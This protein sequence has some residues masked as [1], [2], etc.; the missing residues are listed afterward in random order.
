VTMPERP[1]AAGPRADLEGAATPAEPSRANCVLATIG[2]LALFFGAGFLALIAL[3]I[4]GL[5]CDE[6]C[7]E[8]SGDWHDDPDAWQYDI[9]FVI[10][11]GVLGIAFAALVLATRGR[12]REAGYAAAATVVG[13]AGW[14]IF[15]A[16]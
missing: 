1:E 5:S 11:L 4:N 9:Q 10:A 15:V 3:V 2:T 14:W 7:D 16:V 13:A 12:L 8:G 6:S